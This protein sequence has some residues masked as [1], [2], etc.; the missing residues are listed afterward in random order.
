MSTRSSLLLTKHIPEAYNGA[1]AE[2]KTLADQGDAE[3]AARYAEQLATPGAVRV[4]LD[5]GGGLDVYMV[6]ENG[7]LRVERS[8]PKVPVLFAVGLP[9]EALDLTLEELEDEVKEGLAKLRRRLVRLSPKKTRP[10]IDRVASEQLR[11]HLV[12]T[13]T[14]DFDEVRVKLA[15][16]ASEPPEKPAFTIT[17]AYETFEQLRARKLKPQ[18]LLSK[19]KLSGDSARA[20]QLGMELLQRKT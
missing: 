19:L 17:I 8:A 18:A 12:V 20:M 14:P 4:V 2:L 6:F 9:T 3:A 10:V 16:G 15:T 7:T 1:L 11:F 13:D 5:G